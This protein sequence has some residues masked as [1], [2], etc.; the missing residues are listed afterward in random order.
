MPGLKPCESARPGQASSHRIA[1][2]PRAD[3]F[4]RPTTYSGPFHSFT[5]VI[6]PNGAGKSNL[7]DAISFVLGVRSSSL[8]SAALKD[9][10]YRSGRTTKSKGKGKAVDDQQEQDQSEPEEDGGDDG[11]QVDG[12]RKAWVMAVYID[13]D[14]NDKEWRFQRSSVTRP[15]SCS[16]A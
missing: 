3:R 4:A 13:A 6:G 8:R 14:D 16:N 9:L 2:S 1:V 12:E 7:M 11:D 10:I 5:A 15:P